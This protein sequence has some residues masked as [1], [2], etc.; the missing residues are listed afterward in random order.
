MI[1]TMYIQHQFKDRNAYNNYYKAI[2]ELA[3]N[4]GRKYRLHKDG[5]RY[6]TTAF[7]QKGFLELAL[8]KAKGKYYIGIKFKPSIILYGKDSF[9]LC[10]EHD[11]KLVSARFNKQIEKINNKAY[12]KEL[13]KLKYWQPIR[14]DYALDI[15]DKNNIKLAYQYTYLFKKGYLPKSTINTKTYQDGFY[16]TTKEYRMQFYNKQRQLLEKKNK[17]VDN[18]FRIEVQCN[19]KLLTKMKNKNNWRNYYLP[20]LWQN[21]IMQEIF[22]KKIK[23]LIGENDFLSLKETLNKLS[24]KYLLKQ[25]YQ[26]LKEFIQLLAKHKDTNINKAKEHFTNDNT[27][28]STRYVDQVL[29][30]IRKAG[31]NP[32]TI[33]TSWEIEKIANPLKILKKKIQEQKDNMP[34]FA[35]NE[36]TIV[37][38]IDDFEF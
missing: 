16:I 15:F 20:K 2:D 34:W 4:K 22:T 27:N 33:P 29:E 13:P 11:Y 19:N 1:D 37:D 36:S 17:I 7:Y 24:E 6:L 21:E 14:I 23:S 12:S 8:K 32:I 26:N 25:N 28:L 38:S 31:L 3:Q 9:N 5:K 35:K 30:K 18:I 10:I